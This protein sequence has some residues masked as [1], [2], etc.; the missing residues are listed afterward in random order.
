M[1]ASNPTLSTVLLQMVMFL[2][3]FPITQG[4]TLLPLGIEALLELLGWTEG[5]P[6]C[7]LLS[8]AECAAVVIL[9]RLSLGWLG[10]VLQAREQRI[11]ETVTDRAP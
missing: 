6:I 2:I 4:V 11:L 1:K 8:L 10:A 7:L 9:Y 3:F 5:V